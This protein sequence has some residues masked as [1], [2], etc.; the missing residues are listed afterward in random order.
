MQ[1]WLRHVGFWLLWFHTL[2]IHHAL[3]CCG[4]P[5]NSCA[6]MRRAF[7]ASR[8][9]VVSL[10]W[11]WT[12]QLKLM[13]KSWSVLTCF[14]HLCAGPRPSNKNRVSS[15]QFSFYPGKELLCP[16]PVAGVSP[17]SQKFWS[18]ASE[19]RG[20][21]WGTITTDKQST[22]TYWRH[23]KA[24]PNSKSGARFLFF[25]RARAHSRKRIAWSP[26]DG[27][28]VRDVSFV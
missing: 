19:R 5:C 24:C 8:T 21:S 23:Q 22:S 18:N 12:Q 4:W 17:I 16:H 10:V 7:N 26:K 15:H 6:R 3:R 13:C 9:S 2:V 11:L 14:E 20:K 25:S 1:H 28:W 27:I